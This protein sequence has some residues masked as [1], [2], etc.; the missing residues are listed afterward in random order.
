MYHPIK[1]GCR[2]ISSPVDM[3]ETTICDYMSPQ[4]DLDLED[5]KQIV[6]PDTLAH[7][8]ASP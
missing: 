7:D 8:D 6:L 1:C 5:S 2:K 3:V 4:C